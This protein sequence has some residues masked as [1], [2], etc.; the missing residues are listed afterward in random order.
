[1][2]EFRNDVVEEP[3]PRKQRRR[4]YDMNYRICRKSDRLASLLH[5]RRP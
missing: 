4:V 5:D 1:M 3:A 2:R